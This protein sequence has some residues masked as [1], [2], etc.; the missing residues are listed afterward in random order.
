VLRDPT[1]QTGRRRALR[2]LAALC[3][4]AVAARGAAVTVSSTP[5]DG[6]IGA[7]ATT[8][9]NLFVPIDSPVFDVNVTVSVDLQRPED[10]FDCTNSPPSA[11][12][13]D[14]TITLLGPNGGPSVLLASG[15]AGI[16]ERLH[17]TFNDEASQSIAGLPGVN[18]ETISGSYQSRE[19]LSVLDGTQML[20]TWRLRIANDGASGS[21]NSWSLDLR[22]QWI[23]FDGFESGNRSAWD[24][25]P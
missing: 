20:G 14:L 19:A 4:T 2:S 18:C 10:Q 17:V 5:D 11:R 3:L 16:A 22:T 15:D 24:S 12:L 25:V 21:L 13:D 8:T 23:F 1:L 6:V 7:N 9:W